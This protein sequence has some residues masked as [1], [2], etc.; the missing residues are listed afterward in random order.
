MEDQKKNGAPGLDTTE[1]IIQIMSNSIMNT[2]A[3][4]QPEDWQKIGV[5]KLLREANSL[6][7]VT[8]YKRSRRDPGEAAMQDVN[9]LMFQAM[10]RE[11]P[12]LYEQ[13]RRFLNSKKDEIESSTGRG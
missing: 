10:A 3:N 11:N 13:V 1:A 5:D 8:A 7:K 9:A 12:G 6:V 4:T 2:L